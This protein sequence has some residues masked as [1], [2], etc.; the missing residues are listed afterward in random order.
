MPGFE[1]ADEEAK[2]QIDA[3]GFCKPYEKEYRCK[4]GRVINVLLGAA[5]L[6]N[7]REDG[8]AFLLDITERKTAEEQ[9]RKSQILLQTIFEASA[10]ALFLI[11]AETECIEQY[12]QRAVI[13]FEFKDKQEYIGRKSPTLETRE[14]TEEERKQIQEEI[15]RNHYWSTELEYVGKKG[16]RF[17]GNVAVSFFRIETQSYYLIRI[18]DVTERR[19]IYEEI[20]R[21][22]SELLKEKR[23]TE[24]Q[25]AIIEE[26]NKRKTSELE[27]ARALQL[28]ML[29]QEPPTLPHLALASF[30]KTCV[31]VG[32]D[33]YD[34]KATPDG[35]LTIIV[36]DATGHGL[37][38][39]ILVATVKSYFQ[40]LAGQCDIVEMLQR[41]SEGIHNLQ[42]RA[43]YMGVTVVEIR[44]RE[45]KIAS[46]GMPPV[47]LYR[48]ATQQVESLVFKGPFL[49]STLHSPYHHV[50]KSLRPGDSLLVLTDGLPELFN[51]KRQMLEYPAIQDAFRGSAD[52]PPQQIIDAIIR[53]ADEWT[54]GQP[55]EDDIT[56]L[57]LKAQ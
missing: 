56:L 54:N 49:G 12:N 39:G 45:V 13:L 30:M 21:S 14:F 40:T 55:N 36:G 8:I 22:Q 11:N 23:K 29:P 27:E 38:A 32:G 25:L 10:D 19:A 18:R 15:L 37:K 57:V 51:R 6:E 48:Q 9:L 46:S 17:W 41:I 28:S 43:M 50:T 16:R 33:Y 34:Y 47:F 2:K 24:Q 4:D 31:E 5:S 20:K 52:L 26:D 35:T 42:I 53:L 44:E 3:F 1:Q 7:H